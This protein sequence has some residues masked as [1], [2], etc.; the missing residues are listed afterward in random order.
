M[1]LVILALALNINVFSAN[2][3]IPIIY[4]WKLSSD[5]NKIN[6]IKTDTLLA[7]FQ[8]YD[9]TK[10]NN[11]ISNSFLGNSGQ[12]SISNIFIL[13]NNNPF[14]FFN[15]YNNYLFN[16]N[17]ILFYNTRKHFTNITYITNSS[18]TIGDNRMN[19]LHTQNVNPYFNVGF[20]YKLLSS[21][22]QY[23][24]QSTKNNSFVFFS[25]YNKFRHSIHASYSYNRFKIHDSGGISNDAYIEDE[26]MYS[27]SVGFNTN[28]NNAKSTFL[29]KNL[30]FVNE[31]KLGKKFT[32][33]L[34]DSTIIKDINH[35]ASIIYSLSIENYRKLYYDDSTGFY[36]N[37]Y[38][39]NSN[40]YD[41]TQYNIVSNAVQFKIIPDS[42]GFI[43]VG[44]VGILGAD[45]REYYCYDN[46]SLSFID[47]SIQ[48]N[49]NGKFNKST[50]WKFSNK[51]FFNGQRKNDIFSNINLLKKIKN[52]DSTKIELNIDFSKTKPFLTE[53]FFFSNN[54]KW[55]TT[56][57]SKDRTNIN[58]KYV[59]KKF[60]LNFFI[61][62]SILDNFIYFNEEVIPTQNTST[63]NI[64]TVGII[65]DFKLKKLFSKNILYYQKPDNNYVI[66]L[67]EIC[68]YN[69]SYIEFFLIK[70]ILKTQIGL[71]IYYNTSFYGY[72]YSPATSMFYLQNE[73]E[74]GNYP[75]VDVFM[76]FKLKRARF[77]IKYEHANHNILERRYFLA[78]HYPSQ[79]RMLKVGISWNFYD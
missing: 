5:F 20:N 79:E 71:D 58:L 68:Y 66:R 77:F 28:L 29:N 12:A 51:Y 49:L 30:L 7:N 78:Y 45:I 43:P 26:E 32:R 3:S 33:Q 61:N 11:S 36:N 38:I 41:S 72:S 64:I 65:K 60:N 24:N 35:K 21:V 73:K 40:T 47:N 39:S 56:F 17:N 6:F 52:N 15:S 46:D 22:G 10:R 16:N 18:K 70:N 8:M 67:P 63:F 53:T 48:I 25:S 13:Q 59:N 4:S 54:Y 75:Y 27:T 74:I 23:K 50:E 69:S 14:I 44:I 37:Y 76:N 19:I 9:I 57:L 1:K 42:N 2:D 55:D 34:N 62:Y 31:Y